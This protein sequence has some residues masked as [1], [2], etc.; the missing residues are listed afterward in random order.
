[1]YRC[2]ICT[3]TIA[4]RT[5]LGGKVTTRFRPHRHPARAKANRRIRVDDKWVRPDDPGGIGQQIVAEV[6]ACPLCFEE[7]TEPL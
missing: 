7:A 1:M 4:P 2:G 3:K 5:S 6:D